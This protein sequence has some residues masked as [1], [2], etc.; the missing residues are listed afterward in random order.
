MTLKH[1][2]GYTTDRGSSTITVDPLMAPAERERLEVYNEALRDAE[3][4]GFKPAMVIRLCP[5]TLNPD[6]AAHQSKRLVGVPFERDH[7]DAHIPRLKLAS[8]LSIPIT[9]EAILSPYASAGT[10]FRGTGKADSYAELKGTVDLPMVLACDLVRQ[11]NM[12]NT[13]GGIFKSRAATGECLS[14]CFYSPP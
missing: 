14:R 10:R 9:Y 13:Q 1:S 8:G 11:Q 5:W 2:V 12:L 6:G 4:R 7:W 3:M